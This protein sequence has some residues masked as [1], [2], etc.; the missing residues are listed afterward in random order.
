MIK[1]IL[2]IAIAIIISIIA[3]RLVLFTLKIGF[4]FITFFQSLIM[5]GL[6]ALFAAPLYVII[7]KKL[8]K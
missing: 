3:V 2:S 6:I 7:R 5:I 8:F 1:K 4:I